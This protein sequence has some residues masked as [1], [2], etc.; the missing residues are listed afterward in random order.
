M[1]PVIG[2]RAAV[3]AKRDSRRHELAFFDIRKKLIAKI[4]PDNA[5]SLN[6]CMRLANPS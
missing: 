2:K 1:V 3:G 5:R 6:A 4:H